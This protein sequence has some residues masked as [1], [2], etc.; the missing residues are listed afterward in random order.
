MLKQLTQSLQRQQQELEAMHNRVDRLLAQRRSTAHDADR[1]EYAYV[2]DVVFPQ[3][4]TQARYITFPIPENTEFVAKRLTMYPFF[5][6]VTTDHAANGPDEV[7]FRQCIFAS[8]ESSYAGGRGE[9][10]Q[11]AASVDCFLSLSETYTD[12]KGQR[13]NRF[14]QNMPW[15]VEFLRSGSVN[16]RSGFVFTSSAVRS[17]LYY[18]GFE[19]P[20]AFLFDCD[21]VLPPG[22]NFRLS[23]APIFAGV[24]FDPAETG[25][26]GD[27]TQQ[28]EYK[29]VAVLE[30][31]KKV[32]K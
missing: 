24:R 17:D 7:P 10:R 9:I 31:Y 14:Y 11:H 12:E 20:S 21:Y 8:N 18:D 16:Y 15:P 13:V 6:F 27:D 23:V 28:N 25:P 30:G 3:Q 1:M 26:S 4:D 2:G 19:Y 29:L 22:S 32:I 5:R